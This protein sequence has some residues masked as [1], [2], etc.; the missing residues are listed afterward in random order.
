MRIVDRNTFLAMPPETLFCKYQPCVM[1]SILI[2][3]DSI[4]F[5][6]GN[7]FFYQSIEDAVDCDDCGQMIDVLDSAQLH[8]TSFRLDLECQGRDGCF[9]D[10]QLFVV[11]EQYDVEMLINRLLRC[12]THHR[13]EDQESAPSPSDSQP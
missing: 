4:F 5:E 10:D 6:G 3:G 7:D 8:G 13:A 1:E 11:F 9:D 2:K 12:L